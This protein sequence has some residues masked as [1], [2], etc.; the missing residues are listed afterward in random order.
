MAKWRNYLILGT[1]LQKGQIAAIF[2]TC[3]LSMKVRQSFFI[4]S[5]YILSSMGISFPWS[6]VLSDTGSSSWVSSGGLSICNRTLT[7]PAGAVVSWF[8]AERKYNFVTFVDKNYKFGSNSKTFVQRP[9]MGSQNSGRCWQW[10]LLRG[11]FMKHIEK[12]SPWYS[13]GRY[14]EVV[15]TTGETIF[16]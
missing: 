11:T 8:E 12:W 13:G 1:Q 16:F 9:T 4:F 6:S 10:S 14:S 2:C 3:I 5:K 7:H 15:I